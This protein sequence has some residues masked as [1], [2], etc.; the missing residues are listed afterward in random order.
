MLLAFGRWD[1][2]AT[3]NDESMTQPTERLTWEEKYIILLWL[4]HLLLTPFDLASISSV[5]LPLNPEER[6]QKLDIPESLPWSAKYLVFLGL[7]YI[8]SASRERESAQLLLVRLSVRPDMYQAGLMN[9]LIRW[10]V[11]YLCIDLQPYPHPSIYSCVG[12]LSYLTNVLT[13]AGH[14]IAAQFV[15]SAYRV[16]QDLVSGDSEFYAN[17]RSSALA[18]KALIK[19][20]RTL[21]CLELDLTSQS[22]SFL[23]QNASV[24]LE[25]VIEY[26]LNSLAAKDT[27][28]R[29]A[30]SKAISAI[31]QKME[32]DLARDVVEA[33]L[34]S[35]RDDLGPENLGA[36]DANVD[37]GKVPT[38][39]PA[40]RRVFEEIDFMIANP[41]R[42]HG[43][44]LTLA[45]LLFHRSPPPDQLPDILKFLCLA[46][47]FE[48]R[49]STR[50][51]IGTN[52]RDAACFGIWALSRKY[53]T[54]ELLA[55]DVRSI[56]ATRQFNSAVSVPQI[57]AKELVTTA[58][59]DPTGNIRRGASAALQELVGRHP[60]TVV[61]GISVI[62]VVDY[63]AVALRS[64]AI[65]EVG[66]SAAKLDVSYWYAL[67]SGLLGWRG[68]GSLDARS[69]KAAAAA[70][71]ILSTVEREGLLPTSVLLDSI[72][73]AMA[74]LQVR[75]V[76]Q[77]HG[78]LLSLS[79][80]IDGTTSSLLLRD[81]RRVTDTDGKSANFDT[82]VLSR[83]LHALNMVKD[84]EFKSPSLHPEL[85]AEASCNLIS[86]IARLLGL[87]L[88]KQLQEYL[89][90]E[91][92]TVS[93][94]LIRSSEIL[95]LA[96]TR[97]EEAVIVAS[98]TAVQ[99]LFVLLERQKQNELVETWISC[100]RPNDATKANVSSHEIG[101]LHAL[102]ASY[103]FIG[104][105][106]QRLSHNNDKEQQEIIRTLLQ[107]A[108]PSNAI[109]VRGAALRSLTNGV[110]TCHGILQH[111]RHLR[112]VLM[113]FSAFNEEIVDV[114]RTCLD[115]Y[116]VDSRGDIGSLLRLEAIDAVEVSCRYNHISGLSKDSLTEQAL[117]SRVARLSAEKLD[118]VRLRA[119]GCLFQAWN[120]SHPTLVSK[121]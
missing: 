102:G 56:Q 55:V 19:L 76:E 93:R 75:Q 68:L 96:L 99:R 111:L 100:V 49:S 86:S 92:D 11:S 94:I 65:M 119:I 115:D 23:L 31:A 81:E 112:A 4:S 33:V 64:K 114:L 61:V 15:H 63:H 52:V 29:F 97:S 35:L 37:L 104:C 42:W 105:D 54:L 66:I 121:L 43:L 25:D 34:D 87:A 106:G 2:L 39:A 45:N 70:V 21:T 80:I 62:L 41:L 48:Q 1:A 88:D 72:I 71:G 118:K 9:S 78:M 40:S 60:D 82:T 28:V 30:A 83:A 53:S 12:L 44:I 79:A 7:R 57:L 22:T 8:G 91:Q 89:A 27:P 36:A 51:A 46:L 17:V 113:H 24:V 85:I 32:Q 38:T 74:R 5:G 14:A 6:I 109:E 101:Y 90:S 59:L 77:K 20:Y 26:L 13:S 18:R 69:R 117:L 107:C 103:R 67:L 110:L 58:C 73:M 84:Q 16:A 116:T 10:T 3:T 108:S 95:A 98:T 120:Q 47:Q 50:N